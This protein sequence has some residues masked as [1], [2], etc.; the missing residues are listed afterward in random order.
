MLARF[1]L[2]AL[3]GVTLVGNTVGASALCTSY[4]NT[5]TNGTTADA[6]QVMANFNCAPLTSGS[7]INGLTLTGTTTLPGSSVITSTG[8]IGVQTSSPSAALDVSS[9]FGTFNPTG[10]SI[11]R[12]T[13]PSSVGQSPVDFFINGT[14]RGRMRTDSAGNLNYA[15]FGG[16]QHFFV[17][18]D[19]SVGT[20]AMTVASNGSV[21]IGSTGPIKRLFVKDSVNT[22]TA[23]IATS[24]LSASLAHAYFGNFSDELYLSSGGTYANGW[25]YDSASRSVTYLVM[26]SG[27][28]GGYIAFGTAASNA[29][30]PTERMRVDKNGNVGIGTAAPSYTLHVNGSVAGT[31]A[32]NNLSDARLKKDIHPIIDALA[33]V[34]KMQGVNFNWRL[35]SERSV[36]AAF[37]LPAGKPQVGFIAQD[38]RKV[39]PQAVSIATDKDAIMS[40]AESKIIPVL[41]EAVKELSRQNDELK[42]GNQ[43]QASALLGLQSRMA[44]LE[45][46]MG[47]QTAQN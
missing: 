36:G 17:G 18:G 29:A 21:G 13:N 40:V 12:I 4:P 34:E 10:G 6:T 1:R 47:Q 8:A 24:D 42:A 3:V 5:L 15:A 9:S 35:P 25:T 27:S 39:L 20:E 31:S 14:L 37:K 30:T 11:V 38:L 7:T 19:Y 43:R 33:T 2:A 41:V 32:Y 26:D 45:R 16:G 44:D 28:G 46:R 23:Q 22:N